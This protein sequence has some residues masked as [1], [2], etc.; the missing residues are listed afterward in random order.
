M[1]N[2]VKELRKQL[3]LSQADLAQLVGVSRQTINSLETG[4]YNPS[5]I[6]AYKISN[7]FKLN[8]EKVFVYEEKSNE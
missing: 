4:R 6:L 5:I 7:V 3:N 8:V 2:K 1:N